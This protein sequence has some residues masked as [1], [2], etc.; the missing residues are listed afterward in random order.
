MK[1]KLLLILFISC[2]KILIAQEYIWPLDTPC[3][4]TGN[5]GELRPNH[6]HAGL[7][8]STKN[9]INLPVYATKEGY[10]SRIKISA[11]GYGKSI[12]VTHP[13]GKVT[14]YAHLT[15][16]SKKITDR[17]VQEHYSQKSYEIDFALK[18]TE[19]PIQK[20]EI[21][22]YSGNTGNST[23]PHLHYEIRDE[24]T[25]APQNPL[26][27]Y[28]INDTSVPTLKSIAFY[29]LA[30]TSMPRVISTYAV[31]TSKTNRLSVLKDTI[32]LS[33]GI[34]GLAFNGFDLQTKNGSPN[35]IFSAKVT[36]DERVI[37]KHTLSEISF[38]EQRFVNEFSEVFE[39]LK[40]QKCFVPTLFPN[41]FYD[42]YIRKGRI[43]LTDTNFHTVTLSVNDEQGN[44]TE[45]TFKLKTKK[46][47]YYSE[48]LIKSDVFVDCR[49]DFFITKNKLQ[50]YIPAKTLY[51]STNLIF[52]NTIEQSGKIIILPTEANLKSTSIV[53]FEL[54]TKLRKNKTK[55][56][57]KNGGNTFIPIN[58]NDSVFYSVRNF[59]WFIIDQDTLDP[60]I[61]SVL[62]IAKIKAT[63][64]LKT[65]SFNITD[66][67]SGISTYNCYVN[68][69]WVLAEFD[70]KSNSLNC[71]LPDNLPKGKQQFK[72][73]VTDR[74]KNKSVLEFK[75]D[76]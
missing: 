71:I 35:N 21:I 72:I 67:L 9:K 55:L 60:V 7:D 54:P 57:L 31:K 58:V 16:F 40:Y 13:N 6:F 14:L 39:K 66:N 49:K 68:G 4:I 74:V 30:D 76:K 75:F 70:A 56:V 34:L 12:Y 2:S 23:G 48:T 26:E 28:R 43:I 53:G 41:K 64:N 25:E 36:L 45:L 44:E 42:S 32:I 15:S 10:I 50:I 29:S 38:S 59:G 37:Y 3:V 51:Y 63:K 33:Q 22:A 1:N 61:K 11:T 27:V 73:E 17:I 19:F 69:G 52:E 20:K 65:I 62:P 47:N 24:K 46:L 5:Y 8:F 18:P